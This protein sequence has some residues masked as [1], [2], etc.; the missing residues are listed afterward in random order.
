MIS[1]DKTIEDFFRSLQNTEKDMLVVEDFK[2]R[3]KRVQG[4]F[5][6]D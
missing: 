2:D 3:I 6:E 4:R 1:D 5:S